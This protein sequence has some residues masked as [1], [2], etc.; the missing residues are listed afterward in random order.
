MAKTKGKTQTKKPRAVK[1][2]RKGKVKAAPRQPRPMRLPTMADGVIRRLEEL[3]YE[4]ADVRDARIEQSREEHRLQ[5]LL[6]V[7]MKKHG[8]TAYQRDGIAI[9]V[10]VESEK[11]KVKIKPDDDDTPARSAAPVSVEIGGASA[12]ASGGPDASDG[13]SA[14]DVDL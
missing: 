5:G 10:V 8:K 2:M 6:L 1:A 4:Y 14:G 13:E 3:A 7:E 9:N 12:G 11:V